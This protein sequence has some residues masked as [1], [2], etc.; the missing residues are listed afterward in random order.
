M[1][2]IPPGSAISRRQRD[3]SILKVPFLPFATRGSKPLPDPLPSNALPRALS[4]RDFASSDSRAMTTAERKDPFRETRYPQSTWHLRKETVPFYPMTPKPHREKD[5]MA[6][7][8]I[9]CYSSHC[10]N[11]AWIN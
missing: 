1:Q 4:L 5:A 2:M 9:S 10:Y 8:L 6:R 7:K 11:R 3:A